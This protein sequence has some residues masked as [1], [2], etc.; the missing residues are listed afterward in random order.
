M[1]LFNL[2]SA[3]HEPFNNGFQEA[4]YG[5]T[6]FYIH[7]SLMCGDTAMPIKN[8]RVVIYTNVSFINCCVEVTV[9]F[10]GTI[11]L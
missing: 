6:F 9:K 4:F 8:L 11:P 2:N 10:N 1:R 3:L 5:I 7:L